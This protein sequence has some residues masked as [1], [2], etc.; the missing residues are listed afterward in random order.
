MKNLK[1]KFKILI[2]YKIIQKIFRIFVSLV[3]IFGMA[4]SPFNFRLEKNKAGDLSIKPTI[5]AP[6]VMANNQFVPTNG[7]IRKGSERA[8][9]SV[10]TADSTTGVNVGSWKGTLA[11]DG[12]HWMIDS[13]LPATILI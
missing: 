10:A 12:F 6:P 13:L 11:D 5:K 2:K 1:S 4:I 8:I 3:A 9:T 7:T